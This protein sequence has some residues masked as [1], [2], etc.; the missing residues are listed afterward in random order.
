[1]KI[2]WPSCGRKDGR[3]SRR[4]GREDKIYRIGESR[5]R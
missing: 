2:L 3:K 5:L 4:R 1:V